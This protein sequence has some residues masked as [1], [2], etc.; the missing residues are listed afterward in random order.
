[1]QEKT[2]KLENLSAPWRMSYI[3]TDKASRAQGCPFCLSADGHDDVE[4]FVVKRAEFS[5]IILNAFPYNNFHLMVIPYKHVSDLEEL[6]SEVLTEMMEL[7]VLAKRALKKLSNP[8]GFNMGMNIGKAGG[9]GIAAHLH[10]H[11][12]PRWNGDTNFMTTLG[13]TR[14]CPEELSASAEK[15]RKELEK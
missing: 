12:V 4:R 7:I 5:F 10:L 15:L 2:I 11:L 14:V 13:G 3:A 8:D 9:A 1:M 6:P